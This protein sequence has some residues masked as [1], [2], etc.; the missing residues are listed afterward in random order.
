[1]ACRAQLQVAVTW[2][3]I[4]A[5]LAAI[6]I[7]FPG[8]MI[9]VSSS[10]HASSLATI[11]A[12]LLFDV[13]A[14]LFLYAF[15]L[16][17]LTAAAYTYHGDAT[18]M[19][20]V[21]WTAPD[22]AVIGTRLRAAEVEPGQLSAVTSFSRGLNLATVH[23]ARN[24]PGVLGWVSLWEARWRRPLVITGLVAGAAAGVAADVFPSV[25]VPDK[26]SAALYDGR[27]TPLGLLAIGAAALMLA[28]A[29]Y[30]VA[31]MVRRNIV[32]PS[33]AI[34]IP[35]GWRYHFTGEAGQAAA[36]LCHEF[37][38]LRHGDSLHRRVVAA[39]GNWT[40]FAA[41]F[42]ALT[43]LGIG[44]VGKEE[45][46]ALFYIGFPVM[47][48]AAA[49]GVLATRRARR[50]FI[51]TQEVRADAEVLGRGFTP[52]ELAGGLSALHQVDPDSALAVR[53][54]II[55]ARPYSPFLPG[56]RAM[57]MLTGLGYALP[58]VTL[59]TLSLVAS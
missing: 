30:S 17:R 2:A 4:L 43:A 59:I 16:P 48:I 11:G 22:W 8:E 39:L 28:V 52:A 41:V 54:R 45:P 13:F 36:L 25:R 42:S 14:V 23:R 53:L 31:G 7:L 9:T 1:M 24:L 33:F 27:L 29:A 46:G 34:V 49:G 15:L 5:P 47:I 38:H 35:S 21:D 18:T 56:F 3:A 6:L 20:P 26:A 57:A 32:R 55:T 19:P 44:S 37:S 40:S 12:P 10:E 58:M 50:L 51:L